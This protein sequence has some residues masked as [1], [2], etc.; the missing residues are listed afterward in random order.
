MR[1]GSYKRPSRSAIAF[2]ALVCATTMCGC[3][4]PRIVRDDFDQHIRGQ[5]SDYM[6]S[7]DGRDELDNIIAE[8]IDG[9][10]TETIGGLLMDALPWILGSIGS[11]AALNEWR[12]RKNGHKATANPTRV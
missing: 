7:A 5:C 8:R 6:A 3:A 12:K 1:R 4:I 11:G 9:I 10:V 2:V